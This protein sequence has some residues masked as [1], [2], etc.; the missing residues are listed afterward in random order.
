MD[1]ME[2]PSIGLETMQRDFARNAA[3]QGIAASEF[4]RTAKSVRITP[5]DLLWNLRWPMNRGG[6]LPSEGISP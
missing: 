3:R 1:R 4:H 6:R 2:M 5:K